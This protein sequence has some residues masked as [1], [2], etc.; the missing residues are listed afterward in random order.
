MGILE[1][2]RSLGPFQGLAATV[3]LMA[4]LSIVIS[5]KLGRGGGR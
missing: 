1:V 2:W 3:V 5:T 4:L